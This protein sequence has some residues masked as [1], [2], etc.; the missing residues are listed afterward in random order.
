V[1]RAGVDEIHEA[2]AAV[3]LGKENSSVGL[4]L[5]AL[6]PLQTRPDTAILTAPFAQH[7]ASIT[8]HTHF[9]YKLNEAKHRNREKEEREK[10][11]K[12]R[13]DCMVFVGWRRRISKVV[14]GI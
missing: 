5:G 1:F 12:R 4:G 3:E 9:H 7:S 13:P 6:D 8:A 10:E 14:W 11:G 2:S